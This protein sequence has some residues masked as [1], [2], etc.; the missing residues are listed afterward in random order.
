MRDHIFS[1]ASS[2]SHS[3]H[4]KSPEI[5]Q[6]CA[7]L[8]LSHSLSKSPEAVCHDAGGG[9][10]V[11]GRSEAAHGEVSAV[12]DGLVAA[13]GRHVL[14]H[15]CGFDDGA[16]GGGSGGGRGRRRGVVAKGQWQ[17]RCWR[18]GSWRRSS[19][20]CSRGAVRASVFEK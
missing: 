5:L 18:D 7:S 14:R 13:D 19:D 6:H 10:E 9:C 3:Q 17:T 15:D 12:L 4:S 2:L 16:G 11:P 8:V 1:R 20:G